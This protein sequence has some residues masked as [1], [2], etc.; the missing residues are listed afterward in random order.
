MQSS[1]GH[2][3]SAF[4]CLYHTERLGSLFRYVCALLQ[5]LVPIDYISFSFQH[6]SKSDSVNVL[7]REESLT[8]SLQSFT[9]ASSCRS[10]TTSPREVQ[11][12]LTFRFNKQQSIQHIQSHISTEPF[13]FV[14]FSGLSCNNLSLSWPTIWVPSRATTWMWTW[15]STWDQLMRSRW[16]NLIIL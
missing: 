8:W 13:L 3:F 15:I 2:V 16:K 5:N 11:A 7:T 14:C 12:S 10:G 6:A 9:R 4:C 1:R